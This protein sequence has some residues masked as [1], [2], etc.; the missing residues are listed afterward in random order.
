MESLRRALSIL[1]LLKLLKL[2]QRPLQRPLQPLL[3]RLSTR[4]HSP[5][6]QKPRQRVLSRS[7]HRVR[8]SRRW[9]TS[10]IRALE[11]TE[12]SLILCMG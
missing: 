1:Y 4:H 6:V 9:R 11:R 8:Q 5:Q 7:E 12:G 2:L 3:L 10:R